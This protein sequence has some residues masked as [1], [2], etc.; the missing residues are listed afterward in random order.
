MPKLDMTIAGGLLGRND[1]PM[2]PGVSMSKSVLT[3]RFFLGLKRVFWVFFSLG[4][5]EIGD[6]VT[7]K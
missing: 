3:L 4:I 6:R 2:G 5:F 1:K 7:R